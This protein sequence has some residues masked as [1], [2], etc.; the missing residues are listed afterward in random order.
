MASEAPSPAIPEAV[1][2]MH[3]ESLQ[4]KLSETLQV[5][6]SET[7]PDK[8]PQSLS[9]A[10]SETLPETLPDEL[11]KSEPH[12]QSLPLSLTQSLPET[13]PERQSD[14]LEGTPP[15]CESHPQAHQGV[16]VPH[17]EPNQQSDVQPLLH[18][19]SDLPSQTS[20][21]PSAEQYQP[22]PQP[23]SLPLS[24]TS[25]TAEQLT[26]VKI[27]DGSAR[28]GYS[29]DSA[30]VNHADVSRLG[31]ADSSARVVEEGRGKPL[32]SK[33]AK[34]DAKVTIIS[35][36]ASRAKTKRVIPL[37]A[38]SEIVGAPKVAKKSV[39]K[40]KSGQEKLVQSVP[41][42]KGIRCCV[43]VG[44]TVWTGERGDTITVRDL[45]TGLAQSTVDLQRQLAWCLLLVGAEVWVGTQDGVIFVFSAAAAHTTAPRGPLRELRQ[46]C[47]GVYCLVGS[48]VPTALAFSGSNDFTCNAW[49]A[50]SAAGLFAGHT[51]GVR[52]ALS[53]GD[54][55]FTGSDDHEIRCW[56]AG[57]TECVGVLRGHSEGVLALSTASGLLI[58]GGGDGMILAWSL[59]PSG[60]E[61]NPLLSIPV[62]ES[63]PKISV[64]QLLPV[65]PNIWSGH[66]DGRNRV[67]KLSANPPG[68]KMLRK[69]GEKHGAGC[70]GLSVM[71]FVQRRLVWSLAL[72]G[73][74][75]A[76]LW[77]QEVMD[78]PDDAERLGLA[79]AEAESARHLAHHTQS[80]LQAAFDEAAAQA[81]AAAGTARRADALEELLQRAELEGWL[82]SA[83]AREADNALCRERERCAGLEEQLASELSA[84]RAAEEQI[85]QQREAL[86]LKEGLLG[87]ESERRAQL[88]AELTSARQA[89][90]QRDTLLDGLRAQVC[91]LNNRLEQS[92]GCH[93]RGDCELQLCREE[94]R[95]VDEALGEVQ[96]RCAT[97]AKLH[98]Q[99]RALAAELE[100]KLREVRERLEKETSR[101]H[102]AEQSAT[103]YSM[104][105]ERLKREAQL[106][107]E[108]A[109]LSEEREAELMARL[110]ATDYFKLDVIARELKKVDESLR[111]TKADTATLHRYIKNVKAT[112]EAQTASDALMQALNSLGWSRGHVRDVIQQCLN[113]TQKYHIGAPQEDPFANGDEID[114]TSGG[115]RPM[116]QH[117]RSAQ[118]AS[119][120]PSRVGT[121]MRISARGGSNRRMSD[122]AAQEGVS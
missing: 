79:L 37:P 105:V 66:S 31:V 60:E 3:A 111:T 100:A 107:R 38:D 22:Q 117:N 53:L 103:E 10:L 98:A 21:D 119:S 67:W 101:A 50:S 93:A 71:S 18:P 9:D 68:L 91:S 12:P 44:A 77:Q 4:D 69:L 96:G 63:L 27:S 115:P 39:K 102:A 14:T 5:K 86:A 41:S 81:A 6:L 87:D 24:S 75:A 55:L 58:S 59:R 90:A 76:M 2:E 52:C 45:C 120:E 116:S 74:T 97:E 80:R 33:P 104:Q 99:Q 78:S 51:G 35:R 118:P 28:V 48:T 57:T 85:R 113:E 94:L 70:Q 62:D 11:P 15:V 106:Q 122:S 54:S 64:L 32:T 82:L 65:G 73:P 95:A 7:L 110:K 30:L 121:P 47:G 23:D 29:D 1:P 34:V 19:T 112:D 16:F 20:H 8:L 56:N 25:H 61:W 40:G 109:E 92:E 108:R 13:V 26:R 42:G 17:F 43:K 83:G 114:V 46:H 84:R 88:E 49:T 72:D 89:L 36:T